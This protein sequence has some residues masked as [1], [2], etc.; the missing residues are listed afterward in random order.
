M[1][2]KEPNNL[3]SHPLVHPNGSFP[4]LLPSNI[5]ILFLMAPDQPAK[6]FATTQE[7]IYCHAPHNDTLVNDRL[8]V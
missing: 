8:H 7:L 3:S 6:R 2:H 5:L 4:D 1:R